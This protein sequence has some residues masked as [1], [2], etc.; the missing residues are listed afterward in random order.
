[1]EADGSMLSQQSLGHVPDPSQRQSLQAKTAVTQFK[2]LSVS[3]DAKTSLVECQPLTGRSH[4][5]RSASPLLVITGRMSK[6]VQQ[7]MQCAMGSNM[8]TCTLFVEPELCFSG[9]HGNCVVFLPCETS[10]LHALHLL[11]AIGLPMKQGEFKDTDSSQT[12]QTYVTAIHSIKVMLSC[13]AKTTCR[14]SGR[15]KSQL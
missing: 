1:M 15:T 14:L 6:A 9:L 5:I 8:V 11:A 4:Q 3:A 10:L 13:I 12:C 7:S 2:L